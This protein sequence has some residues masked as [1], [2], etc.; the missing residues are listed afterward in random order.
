M[1]LHPA[2][3][4]SG[5]ICL[6]QA[7]AETPQFQAGKGA[8]SIAK[9]HVNHSQLAGGFNGL[10]IRTTMNHWIPCVGDIFGTE[11]KE[12][13]NALIP[14]HVHYCRTVRII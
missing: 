5:R 2:V 14:R 8:W 9:R 10:A 6:S 12:P 3:F 4:Q 13:L 11:R 1:M 7:S